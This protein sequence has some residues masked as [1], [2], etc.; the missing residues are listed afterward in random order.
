MAPAI[1]RQ[2]ETKTGMSGNYEEHANEALKRFAGKDPAT[3]YNLVD[4]VSGLSVERVLDLGCGAGQELLPFLERTG[5]IC[6]GVDI[7]EELGRV[8]SGTFGGE[9]RASFVR[10]SGACLPFADESFDVVL[11]RVSLPYMNNRAAIAETARV[12]TPNGVLL[13]KTHSPRFYFAML[14]ERLG[15][16]NPK[17]VAYPL[18]CLAAGVWHSATG[19]QLENGIWKGKEIYQ[20]HAFLK[21]ELTK[22]GLRLD[23][24][25]PDDNPLTP[26]YRIVKTATDAILLA[27]GIL[28]AGAENVA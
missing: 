2:I 3:R 8:T 25:L 17:M 16:M 15:S 26:S 11:C 21:A 18:I 7:G 19:K 28:F 23:G 22:R 10:S 6:V 5:A 27:C 4:A 1:Y 9:P 12:L 24:R 14:R 20:T 13:L